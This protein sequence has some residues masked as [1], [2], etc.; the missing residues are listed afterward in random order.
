MK[1]GKTVWTVVFFAGLAHAWGEGSSGRD[2]EEQ[3]LEPKECPQGSRLVQS[4]HPD[5]GYTQ[6]CMDFQGRQHGWGLVWYPDGQAKEYTQAV[7][8]KLDGRALGWFQNGKLEYVSGFRMGERHGL[9]TRWFQDGRKR[10]E[11]RYADGFREGSWR[12]WFPN[13]QMRKRGRYKKGIPEGSWKY[14]TEEG[15]RSRSE[16][17]VKWPKKPPEKPAPVPEPPVRLEAG[18]LV[19][20]PLVNRRLALEDPRLG[21]IKQIAGG[22]PAGG[23]WVVGERGALL[24]DRR[25]DPGRWVKFSRR[26]SQASVL[27]ADGDGEDEFLVRSFVFGHHRLHLCHFLLDSQGSVRWASQ[28]FWGIHPLATGDL[29]GDGRVEFAGPGGWFKSEASGYE[30]GIVVQDSEG[31]TVRRLP[32]AGSSRV[33]IVD[34]DGDGRLEIA[35]VDRRGHLRVQ[36]PQGVVMGKGK[37]GE[38]ARRATLCP[39]PNRGGQPH[40]LYIH[41]TSAWLAGFSGSA[42]LRFDAP[43][44]RTGEVAGAVGIPVRLRPTHRPYLAV[45]VRLRRPQSLLYIMSPRGRVEYL[46][47]IP[48]PVEALGAAALPGRGEEALLVGGNGRV[49]SYRF[50]QLRYDSLA[51]AVFRVFAFGTE[52]IRLADVTPKNVATQLREGWFEWT[53]YIDGPADALEKIACVQYS[54]HPSFPDPHRLV[55]EPGDGPRHFALK[56]EG[57][58]AFTVGIRIFLK[59]GPVQAMQHRLQF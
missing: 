31:S 51:E 52:D 34:R 58:G 3:A 36:D 45:A 30:N 27:D 18:V 25:L 15:T 13:G 14:W 9:F 22:R 50:N 33:F 17:F 57:W 4:D 59:S 28:E 5:R 2:L 49:W 41:E 23:T 1:C 47:V 19:G 37:F 16:V 7:H 20:A 40:L 56:R 8:G 46:E 29:D 44:A 6:V 43:L 53:V 11:G 10:S 42:P 21:R 26:A 38:G 54:L 32:S 39:W 12:Y 35:S 55:C 48:E 24:L